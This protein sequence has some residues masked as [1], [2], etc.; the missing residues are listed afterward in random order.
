M[1]NVVSSS[2]GECFLGGSATVAKVDV[3]KTH[4]TKTAVHL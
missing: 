2:N 3:A 1:A 4:K